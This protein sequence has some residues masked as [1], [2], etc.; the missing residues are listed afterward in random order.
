MVGTNPV[1]RSAPVAI[2]AASHAATPP[3][4][5][6]PRQGRADVA[7]DVTQVALDIVGIFEP[8]SFADLANTGISIWRG[9]GWGA[10]ASFVGV[11]PYVGDAAKLGKLGHWARTIGNAVD[12]A[13]RDPGFAQAVRP[14]LQKVQDAIHAIP[15]GALDALP[16]SARQ[17]LARTGR[18]VDGVLG[19]GT[20]APSFIPSRTAP[21]NSVGGVPGG[22]RATNA[23]DA[24][25]DFK[26]G[27]AR[28]NESADILTGRGYKVE[29]NPHLTDADRAAAGIAPGKNPDYRIVASSMAI[30]RNRRRRAASMPGSRTRWGRGRR[31]ASS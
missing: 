16:A 7:L 22:Q 15:Q 21:T 30:R 25:P 24:A 1:G 10:L 4:G 26:R 5:A 2:D 12:L 6:A 13:R 14:A 23:P 18:E 9:D 11:I 29:Q 27:I 19:T 28:E 3:A 8:T 20:R 31:I 17:H